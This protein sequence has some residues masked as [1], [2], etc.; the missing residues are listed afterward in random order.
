MENKITIALY[1]VLSLTFFSCRQD[2]EFSEQ[3]EKPI[4]VEVELDV[5]GFTPTT[6]R[7]N[8]DGI[9][10]GDIRE[11][12]LLV[13]NPQ[14][15]D[16]TYTVRMSNLH[17]STWRAY[18]LGTIN[19]RKLFFKNGSDSVNIKAV[20]WSNEHYNSFFVNK[21]DRWT[22][23]YNILLD[24]DITFS[25]VYMKNNDPVYVN[26]TIVPK[27]HCPNGKLRLSFRHLFAKVKFFIQLPS[28]MDT[29]L[30]Y[31]LAQESPI[32]DLK[33]YGL[34]GAGYSARYPNWVAASSEINIPEGVLAEPISL[35][36]YEW[37]GGDILTGKYVLM[38]IPQAVA[39]GTFKVSFQYEGKT[40]NWTCG[41]KDFRFETNKEYEIT[42]SIISTRSTAKLSGIIQEGGRP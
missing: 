27:E 5:E 16:Y 3:A 29:F 39:D 41:E 11:F 19:E 8:S 35:G 31:Y 2:D 42:L 17:S 32:K 23:A 22:R 38:V 7:V 30:K 18:E 26:T 40:Y 6:T 4:P 24:K 21:P 13:E 12:F 25:W 34:Y 36:G 28:D 33:I 1:I 15:P 14:D 10:A 9:S 37:R 20:C